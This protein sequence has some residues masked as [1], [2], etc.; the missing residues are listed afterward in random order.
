MGNKN[1][2]RGTSFRLL[3]RIYRGMVLLS[4]I[5]SKSSLNVL[6][7]PALS[8]EPWT[9]CVTGYWHVSVFMFIS[10]VHVCALCCVLIAAQ[11]RACVGGG[12]QSCFKTICSSEYFS[13][14]LSLWFDQRTSQ[15]NSKAQAVSRACSGKKKILQSLPRT[16][17]SV[18]CTRFPFF[19][20]LSKSHG[21]AQGTIFTMK[22][23]FLA[24]SRACV[25]AFLV[26]GSNFN[27]VK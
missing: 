7:M 23:F 14:G 2:N 13:G 21:E 27:T 24:Q 1:K 10:R 19:I 18:L 17:G 8:A 16:M 12:E 9:A 26:C 4:V 3:Q 20:A 5:T 6:F 25:R 22:M 11:R 15:A